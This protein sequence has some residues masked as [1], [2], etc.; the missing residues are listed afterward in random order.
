MCEDETDRLEGLELSVLR[1][2]DFAARGTGQRFAFAS[3]DRGLVVDSS[4][5]YIFVLFVWIRT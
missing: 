1:H 2:D 4:R 3:H 5:P